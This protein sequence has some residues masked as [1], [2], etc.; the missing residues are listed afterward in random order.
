MSA[1]LMVPA[2]TTPSAPAYTVTE[3]GNDYRVWQRTLSV[4]NS[5]TSQITQQVQS[6]RE[7]GN[8][9]CHQGPDGSWIDSQ[10]VVETTAAGAQAVQGPLQAYFSSDI[11]A[12]NA[13]SLVPPSTDATSVARLQSRPLG[14]FY[15]DPTVDKVARIGLV[16]SGQAVI[17]PPN[18]LVYQDV[19][20]G[21]ADLMVVW[22]KG[23]CEESLV[24]KRSP[25]PPQSFGLTS[26]ARLQYWSA[27][28]C[29][30]PKEQRPVLLRSGLTDHIIIFDSCWLPW[31]VCS[32]LATHPCRRSANR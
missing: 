22:T 15:Y 25:P 10:D 23:G 18:T 19:I 13:I 28:Q 3:R 7:L 12:S 26:A 21:L 16:Q 27:F 11:T 1:R 6:Y 32:F 4:T 29:P 5:L 31:E 2:Q 24:I 30:E 9:I 8:G 20:P 17:H 14:L